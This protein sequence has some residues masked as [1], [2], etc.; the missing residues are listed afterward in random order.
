MLECVFGRVYVIKHMCLG[1]CLDVNLHLGMSVCL[2]VCL[3]NV[4]DVI[5]CSDVLVSL[6][7]RVILCVWL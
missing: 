3:W 7:A 4:L 2:S 1:L 6:D 5:V